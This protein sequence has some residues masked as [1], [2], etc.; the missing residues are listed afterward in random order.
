MNEGGAV[1]RGFLIVVAICLSFVSAMIAARMAA[2]GSSPGRIALCVGELWAAFVLWVAVLGSLSAALGGPTATPAGGKLSDLSSRLAALEG[3]ARLWAI[4]G[5][6]ASAAIIAHL[7]WSL[8]RTM[9][10]G[11]GT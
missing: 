1:D 6:A 4:A 7:L 11:I 8:R 3:A 10:S 5:A 9:S 2:G